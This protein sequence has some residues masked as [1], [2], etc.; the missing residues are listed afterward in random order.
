MNFTFTAHPTPEGMVLQPRRDGKTETVVSLTEQEKHD[1]CGAPVTALRT[2]L[3]STASGLA[4]I[5]GDLSDD[6]FSKEAKRR[7]ASIV[8]PFGMVVE[9]TYAARK[10]VD[11]TLAKLHTPRFPDESEPAVRAEQR[12]FA[13]GLSMAARIEAANRDPLLAA[14]IVEGG[15]AM[16]GMPA[17][18]FDRMKREMAV[19]QLT[20]ALLKGQDFR[21][22]Q[23]VDDPIAGKPD[24]DAA[25]NV[26]EKRLANLESERE[27]LDTLPALLSHVINAVALMSGETRQAA[28]ERLTA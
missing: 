2:A 4:E 9:S 15:L 18:V 22:P 25:R 27:L 19:G 5:A 8:Q 17:D 16:S 24:R 28:F 6:G 11:E 7:T 12:S 26:A 14:A 23:T 20:D 13:S 21:T 1:R 3:A 10:S